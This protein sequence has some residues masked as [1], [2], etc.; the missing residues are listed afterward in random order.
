MA[1]HM[2]NVLEQYG[3]EAQIRNANLFSVA[4][5]LPI[6]ECMPEVWVKPLD[7][8]R[9][10]QIIRELELAED[11]SEPDWCCPGCGE[12]N[13]GNFAICWRCQYARDIESG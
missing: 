13:A 12:N 10:E 8:R 3:I 2:R 7:E 1:W 11:G 9:A 4:G 6:N 5:E